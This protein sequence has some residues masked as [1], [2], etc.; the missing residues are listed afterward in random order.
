MGI[1]NRFFPDRGL[2]IDITTG[3][4]KLS[5][6]Q[7]Y[8]A[9]LKF[10]QRIPMVNKI[11][12]IVNDARFIFAPK[13]VDEYTAVQKKIAKETQIR[14]AIVVTSPSATVFAT[15]V[16]KDSFFNDKILVCSTM[17]AACHFLQISVSE[18]D[19]SESEFNYYPPSTIYQSQPS[20]L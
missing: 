19:L 14:W 5:D 20:I 13:E 3:D 6:L 10:D 17:Q 18:D 11:L 9:A 2:L 15:L 4:I 16:E 8:Q 1:K 7:E 12:S